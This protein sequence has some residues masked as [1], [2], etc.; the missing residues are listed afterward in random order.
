M[1]PNFREGRLTF[2][3]LRG[4]EKETKEQ[5]SGQVYSD[6]AGRICGPMSTNWW[7]SYSLVRWV[8]GCLG[9]VC[10][11]FF[12][13]KFFFACTSASTI[14]FNFLDS[15]PGS[16][17]SICSVTYSS[18]KRKSSPKN[19]PKGA[20]PERMHFNIRGIRG[21]PG[22]L[23]PIFLPTIHLFLGPPRSLLLLSI[24]LSTIPLIS[25]AESS[26]RTSSHT[27]RP[28]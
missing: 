26:S 13:P 10:V 27:L 15:S 17:G 22:P 19:F 2:G 25:I 24:T 3:L 20:L 12:F 4:K 21:S 23:P 1:S 28:R 7:L 16:T 5:K 11:S 6:A 8:G 18:W 14:Q 9:W